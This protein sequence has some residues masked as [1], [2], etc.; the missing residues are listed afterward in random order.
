MAIKITSDST[1]DLGELIEKRN[2]GI[3]AFQVNLDGKAYFDGVDITP[4][5][6]FAFVAETRQLPK[7]A[8]PSIGDYEEY[9]HDMDEVDDYFANYDASDIFEIAHNGYFDTSDYYFVDGIYVESFDD[10]YEHVDEER[11][12]TY[13]VD[14]DDNLGNGDLLDLMMDDEYIEA[15]FE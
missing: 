14:S 3:L 10:I 7:T 11:L 4:A 2:I 5:D 1:C 15:D 13:I 9:I 6:I 12:V 8:A